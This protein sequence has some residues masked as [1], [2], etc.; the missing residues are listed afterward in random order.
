MA[1]DWRMIWLRGA[2][3]VLA[4]SIWLAVFKDDKSQLLWL[5][6]SDFDLNAGDKFL[7]A[8]Y[9][10]GKITKNKGRR[11]Q[12]ASP[13]WFA[14]DDVVRIKRVWRQRY[15][16]KYGV[17]RKALELAAERRGVDPHSLD[18]Y[19]NRSKRSRSRSKSR[20]KGI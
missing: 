18:N 1:T 10:E 13:M 11:W 16:R 15:G 7:L 6:R 8:D 17:H 3:D 4:T 14:A 19:I 9:I 12:G 5:L 20:A 2:N